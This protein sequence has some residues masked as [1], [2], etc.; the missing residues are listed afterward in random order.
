MYFKVLK[1][2][3]MDLNESRVIT[4]NAPISCIQLRLGLQF[5]RKNLNRSDRLSQPI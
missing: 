3:S 1:L 4:M 2:T 5:R